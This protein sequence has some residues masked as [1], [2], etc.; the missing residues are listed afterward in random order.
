[1]HIIFV[2]TQIIYIC[3][4]VFL[5]RM[6]SKGDPLFTQL[7]DVYSDVNQKLIC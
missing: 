3:F 6:P 1:M 4:T 5:G 2:T 7:P